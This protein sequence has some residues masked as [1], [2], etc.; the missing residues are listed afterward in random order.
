MTG[1]GQKLTLGPVRARSA[2][3][4]TADMR[5]PWR[6]VRFVATVFIG[7][8]SA[9]GAPMM[10]LTRRV[11]NAL[12]VAVDRPKGRDARELDG[13]TAFGRARYHFRRCQND[14]QAAL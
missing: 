9:S 12:D 1:L 8:S 13:T 2:H 5:A 14:R 10:V 7:P 4:L 6:H 3:P 11:K